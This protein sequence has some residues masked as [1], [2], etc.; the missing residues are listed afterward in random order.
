VYQQL[1]GAA[2]E[3]GVTMEELVE[4]VGDDDTVV[5]VGS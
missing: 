5:L 2:D 4:K 1:S 3:A